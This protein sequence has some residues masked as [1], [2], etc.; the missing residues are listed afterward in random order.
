MKDPINLE[1]L[2]RRNVDRKKVKEKRQVL[3]QVLSWIVTESIFE[4]NLI[5]LVG[6]NGFS[7]LAGK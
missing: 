5:I 6:T 2:D 3:N 7:E 1:A 4:T